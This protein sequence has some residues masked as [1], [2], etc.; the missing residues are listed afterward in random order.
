[1]LLVTSICPIRLKVHPTEGNHTCYWKA[2]QLPTYEVMDPRR[3]STT[4][5]AVD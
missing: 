5:T 2:S 4:T 1:M 3:V